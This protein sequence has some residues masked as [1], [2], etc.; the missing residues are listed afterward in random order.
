LLNKKELEDKKMTKDS[1]I[2]KNK[3]GLLKL[4]ET[5]GNVSEA[6]KVLGYSRDSFYRFKELYEIGGDLAL[7]EISRRKPILK[8][9]VEQEIEEAVKSF[10]TEQPAYGQVRVSN[11]LRKQ[12]KFIS[13]GGV[14]SVW[15]RHDLETFQKRLKALE[16]KSAQ[17]N[18]ILTE[19]QVKAL[20]KAKDQKEIKGEIE[21][22][23][24]GY[25]GSQDTFYVGTIKGVGRIYQQTFIDTYTKVALCKLYDRK[26][27]LVAAEILN[28]KVIPFYEEHEL[29]LLRIL[30]DRGTEYC[31]AREHHSYQL[32]LSIEDIDHTTTKARSPQTNGICERFHRTIL[33]EFYSVAFR[34][35]IYQSIEELQ[36]DLDNWL[37]EYNKER[38][39]SG[40]Y[41]Y[42][43]T[44]YQT[45]I[46]SI[47]LAKEKYLD[48]IPN[49]T[50]KFVKLDEAETSS[51]GEQLVR[52][53]PTDWNSQGV[54][55]N[56]T[57]IN[58]KNNILV[59]DA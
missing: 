22:H 24:P 40:K 4:A 11:E 26:N 1:K 43:K 39:H 8:N 19:S 41:C 58:V 31:G 44:P 12:G 46:E 27:S 20:E 6:C 10:A 21:T 51:A 53:N 49:K 38:P 36:Q 9:R 30:T 48:E 28:D 23:H 7:K 18:L 3:V 34:K 45:F 50:T 47:E 52:N 17:E 57:S 29:R 16:A 54:G 35:K 42:G 5:L 33:N 25:L 13:P 55:Q 32:Y 14:R 2:I 56:P 59:S 37:E 15:L